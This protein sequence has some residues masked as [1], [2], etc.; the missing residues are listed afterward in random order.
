MAQPALA[1]AAGTPMIHVAS[2]GTPGARTAPSGG[3]RLTRRGRF[4]LIGLPVLLVAAVLLVVAGVFTAPA[5]A[6]DG[7]TGEPLR[8]ELVTTMAGDTLW[9]LASEF[10]PERDPRSVIREITELNGLT[11]QTILPGQQLY[12]P[13][14]G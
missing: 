12:V 9:G 7:S 6:A 13:T 5:M 11:S 4:V 1:A 3:L 8:A 14:G 2:T 10:A